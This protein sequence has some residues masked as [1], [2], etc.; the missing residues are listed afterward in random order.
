MEG[1]LSAVGAVQETPRPQFPMRPRKGRGA[2]TQFWLGIF[3]PV[4]SE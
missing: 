3:L 4:E 1:L 2:D